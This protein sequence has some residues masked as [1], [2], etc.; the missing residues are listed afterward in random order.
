LDKQ[1]KANLY[2]LKSSGK[3]SA[4]VIG[5]YNSNVTIDDILSR[6]GYQVCDARA[7]RPGGS[8]Y[9]IFI[10][11]EK[12]RSFH[13]N[14]NDPLGDGYWH[15]PFDVFCL[16]E[17]QGNIS[18]AVRTAAEMFGLHCKTQKMNLT[19]I[20]MDFRTFASTI[21]TSAMWWMIQFRHYHR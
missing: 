1:N 17:H 4:D 18:A 13:H 9:S 5:S 20:K 2:H 11:K 16:L 8:H 19:R 15:S 7:I 3:Q 6:N 21:A 12:N 14:T 10:S